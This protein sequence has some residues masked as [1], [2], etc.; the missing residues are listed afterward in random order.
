MPLRGLFANRQQGVRRTAERRYHN[1]R[2]PVQPAV[3]D[4]GGSLDRLGVTNGGTAE[5]DDDH[6]ESR[7]PVVASSSAL[8][9]DPPAA[10]RTV[11]WPSATILRSSTASRRTRPTVTVIP[12]PAFTSRFG[13]G[14]SSASVTTSGCFGRVGSSF[15][16]GSPSHVLIVSIAASGVGASSKP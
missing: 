2:L 12:L 9:T 15:V 11:L 5:L 14:R 6:A 13:C 16:E 7:P 1:S 4:R 3:H 10:P 8:S